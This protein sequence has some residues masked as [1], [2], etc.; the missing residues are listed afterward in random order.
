MKRNHALMAAVLL[1]LSGVVSA[2]GGAGVSAKSP[3]R[4]QEERP[5]FYA[6]RVI[7]EENVKNAKEALGEPDGRY[8]EIAPGGRMVLLM[9]N[10]IY[11]SM[12]SD[13]GLVVCKGEANFGMEGWFLLAGTK[14][15]PQF[16]WMPLVRGMVPGGFRLTGQ[17]AMGGTAE[18]SPGV[19]MIR[20]ANDDMKPILVDALVGYGR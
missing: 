17:E 9:E 1:V 11:P 2:A 5:K 4:G 20:I 19:N 14:D 6:S 13:D 3:R 16:A 10:R 18:G 12:T 7:S 15:A 8:A